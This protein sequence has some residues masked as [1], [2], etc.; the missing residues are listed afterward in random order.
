MSDRQKE[1]AMD[2]FFTIQ[3][4]IADKVHRLR[5][6]RSEEVLARRAAKLVNEKI[7][8]YGGHFNNSEIGLTDLLAMVAF[9]FSVEKLK[10]EETQDVSP[11]HDKIEELSQTV[12]E[13]LNS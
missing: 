8:Q 11:I 9:H 2:D 4:N 6:R 13:Y 5:C 7:L 3:L 10:I 1:D 12:E